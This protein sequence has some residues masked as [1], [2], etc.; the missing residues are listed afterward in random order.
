[1]RA[2]SS[3]CC[4]SK[5]IK[6][7]LDNAGWYAILERLNEL[8]DLCLYSAQLTLSGRD[9]GTRRHPEAVH[10]PSEFMAELLEQVASKQL[11]LQCMQNPRLDFVSSDRQAI[12]TSPFVASP[13]TRKA[14]SRLQDEAASTHAAFGESREQVLRSARLDDARC[15]SKNP[16]G[17]ILPSFGVQ[18]QLV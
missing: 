4:A 17:R 3:V 5:V 6:G 16:S 9:A 18:P 2:R 11:F 14:M 13:K 1:M 7:V 15:G 10:L 12:C 8:S